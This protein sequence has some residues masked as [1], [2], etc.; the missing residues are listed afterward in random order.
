MNEKP[1]PDRSFRKSTF[2]SPDGGCV[3]VGVSEG[4]IRVR[5]SKERDGSVLTFNAREWRA[6]LRGA[7]AGEFDLPE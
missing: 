3:E 6:F 1:V 4:L 7:K 2:S 5:D